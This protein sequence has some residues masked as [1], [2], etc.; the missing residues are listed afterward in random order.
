MSHLG[1]ADLG[2]CTFND[3][4]QNAAMLASLSPCIPLIADADTGYGGPIMV[5]RTVT[6]YAR[7]RV[8]GLH[9]EDQ[10][11]EKRCGQLLGKQLVEAEIWYARLRAAVAARDAVGSEML[12]IARTDAEAVEGL[13]EAVRRL[14][15][16]RE[17]GVD[18]LFLEAL[19]SIEEA[20]IACAH[21]KGMPLLLSMVPGG[22]TPA[23]DV[24]MARSLGF[25][26]MI[27]PAVW[28]EAV[29]KSV[30]A[31]VKE[32]LTKGFVDAEGEAKGIRRA[33]EICGLKDPIEIDEKAGREAFKS[34]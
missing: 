2:L 30:D 28:I 34:I 13:D 18:V 5:A 6:A 16:A 11:Q 15:R 24:A 3:M 27:F 29:M 22:K 4:H 14:E 20:K 12:I 23:M 25:R 26:I 21:F 10:V 1:M 32:L 7:A 17:I 31:S 8:A 19:E 33:F 9:I